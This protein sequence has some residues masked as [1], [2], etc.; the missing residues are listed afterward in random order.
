MVFLVDTNDIKK[1]INMNIKFLS[2]GAFVFC[3]MLM[4][5]S[6]GNKGK[7]TSYSWSEQNYEETEVNVIEQCLPTIMVIPSDNLLNKSNSFDIKGQTMSKDYVGFMQRNKDAKTFISVIQNY[8]IKMDY[9]L[10]D[11][12]QTLKY[13]SHNAELDMADGL[14]KDARTLLLT[15]VS[16]DIILEFDYEYKYD[17]NSTSLEKNLKY[18]INAIDTY[19]N[20]VFASVTSDVNKGNDFFGNLNKS[21]NGNLDKLSTDIQKYFS[22]IAYKGREITVRIAVERNSNINLSDE[23]IEGDTYADWIIDYMKVNTIKGTYKLQ[24]N[25]NNELFF[26]NVRINVI[27]NDG[28]QFSAY[29]WGRELSKSIRKNL[30]VKTTNKTQGLG[31]V[32]ITIKGL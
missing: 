10:T 4:S 26:E 23:S 11:L 1:G 17:E 22:D 32:L 18:R 13:I 7:L 3:A 2:I 27:N 21:S 29:D 31:N 20:K 30:G 6:G 9:P 24:R 12:E 15:T 25:T 5:C 8:F 19:T 16:P 14:E 28:T